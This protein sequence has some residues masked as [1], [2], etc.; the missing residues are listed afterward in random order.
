M[1]PD[2]R[3]WLFCYGTLCDDSTFARVTQSTA[4]PLVPATLEGWRQF[5]VPGVP[6]PA[7]VPASP[8]HRV[9]GG[10]REISSDTIWTR[11][12]EYEGSEYTRVDC[13][14]KAASGAIEAQ[15]YRYGF[16]GAPISNQ[17]R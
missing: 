6:Y 7:A 8:Q 12:D 13:V 15:V 4:T 3:R 17:P 2:N 10:L 14:V 9:E 1:A 5:N 16:G 11:L